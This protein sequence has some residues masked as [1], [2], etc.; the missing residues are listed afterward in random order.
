MGDYDLDYQFQHKILPEMFFRKP[1]VFMQSFVEGGNEMLCQVHSIG[2]QQYGV[3]FPYKP[4]QYEVVGEAINRD[5]Y[6]L[7]L[8]FPEPE[9][10]ALCYYIFLVFDPDLERLSFFTLEKGEA[11][12]GKDEMAFL[13]GWTPDGS[14]LTYGNVETPEY[15]V[16]YR[17]VEIH[18]R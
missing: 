13:C 4:E 14:H 5:L 9:V 16:L 3:S 10:T 7:T 18:N 11:F 1:N 15:D 17:C 6:A 12:F 2:Y 8:K